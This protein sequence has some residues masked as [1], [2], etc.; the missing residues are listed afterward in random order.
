V[1]TV[2]ISGKLNKR[3]IETMSRGI[4]RSHFHT[5]IHLILPPLRQT[6]QLSKNN[7]VYILKQKKTPKFN[8]K[9]P[10]RSIL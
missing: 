9:K 3:D 2:Q 7:Y 6:N 4:S 8:R 10:K 5:S 1:I